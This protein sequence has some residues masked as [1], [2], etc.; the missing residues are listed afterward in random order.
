[1]APLVANVQSD[2][3]KE[4]MTRAQS[5][6]RLVLCASV[7]MITL[8]H[9]S[10]TSVFSAEW[11]PERNVEI[12]AGAGPG[13]AFDTAARTIERVIQRNN[14]LKTTTTVVNKS[15]GGGSVAWAYLNQ[16]PAD[17]HHIAV[18]VLNILTNQIN[19]SSN[20]RYT[21]FTTLARLFDEYVLFAVRT[22]SPVKNGQ[23]LIRKLKND[24]SSSSVAIATAAGGAIHIGAGLVLKAGGVDVGRVRFVVFDSSAKSAIAVLGG[25]VDVVASSPTI[26]VP[27]FAAGK[28][29]VLGISSPKRMGGTLAEV[30]TWKEQNVDAIFATWRGVIGPRDMNA[31]QIAFWDNALRSLT[32]QDEW[33]AELKKNLWEDSYLD[34]KAARAD[35]DRQFVQLKA[36]LDELGVR[37]EKR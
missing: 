33:R 14:L 23:D 36:I 27:Q 9:F 28:M 37:K 16:H 2:N 24:P 10:V 20:L 3:S 4:D 8:P 19:E 6:A 18:T 29:R 31:G 25:H 26:V 5:L 30:P 7:C 12:I 1:M 15:G 32:S 13:S 11:A 17:G 35:L 34:S 22:D 21:E